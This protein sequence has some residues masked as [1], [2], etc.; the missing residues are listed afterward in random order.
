MLVIKI[1]ILVFA[2]VGALD[3]VF[4]G[5]F[6]LGKEFVN[7]LMLMGT[8]LLSMQG[9][10]VISPLLADMLERDRADST[11]SVAPAVAAPDATH[12]DNSWMTPDECVSGILAIV[13]EKLGK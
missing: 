10:I 9:M 3:Y 4:G 6:G 5:R 2:I 7:G 13:E 1:V 12:F 8:M 11:R